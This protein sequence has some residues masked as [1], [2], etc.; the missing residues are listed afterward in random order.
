ML[1]NPTIVRETIGGKLRRLANDARQLDHWSK[2][3]MLAATPWTPSTVFG[4]IGL[5]VCNAGKLFVCVTAGTSAASGGPNA[6]TAATITDNTASW[7]YFGDIVTTESAGETIASWVGSTAY[8]VGAKVKLS[9]YV[10][11]CVVAGTSASS[12][13]PSGTGTG[14]T[15]GTATWNYYGVYRASPYTDYP[16]YTGNQSNPGYSNVYNPQATGGRYPFKLRGCYEV[17][18]L[19][20]DYKTVA[21]FKPAAPASNLIQYAA[22]EF[23]TNASRLYIRHSSNAAPIAIVVDG[24]RLSIEQVKQFAS[25]T[26]YHTLDWTNTG[27]AKTRRIKL[28][29]LP[30]MPTVAV[31]SQ[32]QIW[33]VA[34]DSDIKAVFISD[35]IMAGSS[36]GPFVRGNNVSQRV[37]TN[38]GWA[39]CWSFTQGGTGYV[40]RG[41]NAGVTT[42]KYSYRITEA[43][44]LNP[45]VWV[46]MGSTNDTGQGVATISAAVVSTLSSIRAVSDAPIVVLG[47]WPLNS[48][49]TLTGTTTSGSATISSISSIANLVVG[50][51]ITGTGIQSGTQIVTIGGSSITVSKTATANGTPTLTVPTTLT[52]ENAVKAGVT[53]L[54]DPKVFFVPIALETVPWVTGSWNNAIQIQSSNAASLIGGDSTHPTDFG[55]AYV[56]ERISAAIRTQVLPNI[57]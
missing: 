27:G 52:T 56:C 41:T 21:T 51:T 13:G 42:D 36:Y 1:N 29:N 28:E 7:T 26:S 32:Y 44:T 16:T 23:M 18:N 22:M 39:D 47:V 8:T 50:Q 30:E 33:P 54:A 15:D 12:G 57:V 35:S 20:S 48:T 37:G 53:S 19:G 40:N 10:F 34:Q 5:V 24:V 6:T 55:T 17:A 45:D 49:A 25:G 4:Y 9:G 43:A 11:A 46:L 2:P 14:I 31:D 3:P 38:L